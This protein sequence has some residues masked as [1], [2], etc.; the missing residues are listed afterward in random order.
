MKKQAEKTKKI[1]LGKVQKIILAA[2]AALL[3]IATVLLIVFSSTQHPLEKFAAKMVRKQ[4]FQMD[5]VLSGI[6]FFGTVALTYEMDGNIQ[7][8]P[9]GSFTSES[10]IEMVG[11]KQY[12]YTKDDTGKWTKKEG[13]NNLLASIQDNEALKQLLDVDNYEEVEGKKN[14]YRQKADVVFENCRDVTITL[15]DNS[16]IIEMVT[17]TDGMALDTLIVISNV[18][19]VN[20]TLPFVIE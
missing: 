11:D 14:V 9:A 17:L 5:V 19:K 4:S 7:H 20:L 8:I 10:Y 1:Q 18:G 3:C 12:Q 2:V 13:D 6:P 16:C 15:E